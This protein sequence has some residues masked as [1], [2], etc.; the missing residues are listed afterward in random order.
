MTD[1][2]ALFRPAPSPDLEGS[3][4]RQQR[5]ASAVLR[6]CER[7]FSTVLLADEVGMGKTYVALAVM[8]GV[9]AKGGKTL[10]IVPGNAVLLQKW[11]E[12]IKTFNAS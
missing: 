3:W 6:R 7:G 5:E 12:E 4:L 11:H 1:F 2:S 8:A 10:L 9:A